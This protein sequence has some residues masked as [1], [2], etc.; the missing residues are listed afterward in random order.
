[1]RYRIELESSG[2][3]SVE[4]ATYRSRVA[5]GGCRVWTCTDAG[6]PECAIWWKCGN[7]HREEFLY[8]RKHG[9]EM[10]PI[11]ANGRMKCRSCDEFS[12]PM[13]EGAPEWPF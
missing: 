7:G 11:A 3:T 5:T 4:I 12:W 1:M 6:L 13:I 9:P 2:K 10:L 8:C